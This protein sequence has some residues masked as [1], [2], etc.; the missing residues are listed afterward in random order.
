[1]TIW[2]GSWENVP[3]IT[4]QES[5]GYLNINQD[6]Q[7]TRFRLEVEHM[8]GPQTGRSADNGRHAPGSARAFLT[9]TALSPGSLDSSVHDY[10]GSGVSGGG[11]NGL[12]DGR[13]WVSK[14]GSDGVYPSADDY[15]LWVYDTGN[16]LWNPVVA[17]PGPTNTATVATA[18]VT[19]ET[20]IATN[21]SSPTQLGSSAAVT[22]PATGSFYVQVFAST[23][24]YAASACIYVGLK[25]NGSVVRVAKVNGVT[26]GAFVTFDYI[27][28]SPAISTTYTYTLEY[29]SSAASS[30]FNP[31]VSVGA[32]YSMTTGATETKIQAVIKSKKDLI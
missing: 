32:G 19:T 22:T 12:D 4:D 6:K 17:N 31:G 28:A 15:S 14:D 8:V 11:S 23:S 2:D 20:L 7:E 26:M 13:L 30:Y 5:Q 29:Q 1:M 16:N 21:P 25:E 27:L 3:L 18:S 24:V 10:S 9:T